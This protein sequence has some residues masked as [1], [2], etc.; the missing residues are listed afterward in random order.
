[1]EN[2]RK[3]RALQ[4][5]LTCTSLAEAARKAGISDR[6]LYNYLHNDQEFTEAYAAERARLVSAAADALKKNAIPAIQTLRKIV[7]D[8]EAPPAVRVQACRT[9]LEYTLKTTEINDIMQRLEAL[10]KAREE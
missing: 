4:A 5:L 6:T 1:M 2:E 10:E 3:K 7:D 9:I 8:S